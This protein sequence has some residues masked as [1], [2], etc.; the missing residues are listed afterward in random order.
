[1]IH[2]SPRLQP[3]RSETICRHDQS[4]RD[5]L[6]GQLLASVVA[7]SQLPERLDLLIQTSND[8]GITVLLSQAVPFNDPTVTEE[9][10]DQ[11]FFETVV[12][13]SFGSV[14]LPRSTCSSFVTCVRRS[15]SSAA[16]M[17]CR[18]VNSRAE[19]GSLR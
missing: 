4:A 2:K 7:L 1:L 8:L 10:E 19:K 17:L 16:W 6:H 9:A 18:A 14:F 15:L 11:S 5:R 3:W 13:W 12:Q